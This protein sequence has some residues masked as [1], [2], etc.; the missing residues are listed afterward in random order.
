MQR[1]AGFPHHNIAAAG[2]KP[3]FPA[4]GFRPY[5]PGCGEAANRPRHPPEPNLAAPGP[6][7][8]IRPEP[9]HL[10]PSGSGPH[11]HL[12]SQIRGHDIPGARFQNNV[13]KRGRDIHDQLNGPKVAIRGRH[14]ERN[15]VPAG[16]RLY[17]QFLRR[18]AAAGQSA[19]HVHD[20]IPLRLAANDQRTLGGNLQPRGYGDRKRTPPH[21]RQLRLGMEA[22]QAQDARS[23]KPE[24]QNGST[25]AFIS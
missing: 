8:Q 2:L 13:R 22:G 1:P 6:D 17:L 7:F 25:E 5:P 21:D 16:T 14:R 9:I 24:H 3:G 19:K 11:Q 18:I 12:A 4:H 15:Q 20:P 23:D 10:D